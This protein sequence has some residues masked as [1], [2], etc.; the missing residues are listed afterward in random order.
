MIIS[1]V[2][3]Q[4]FF[5]YKELLMTERTYKKDI[6]VIA[7]HFR[8]ELMLVIKQQQDQCTGN[9]YKFDNEALIH[10]SD[11]LLIHLLPI[12]KFHSNLLRQL[13]HKI[14]VW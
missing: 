6:Q 11:V 1:P 10:L 13:E 3:D 9:E 7:E 2:N 12:Y 4:L 5:I 8:R 14:S